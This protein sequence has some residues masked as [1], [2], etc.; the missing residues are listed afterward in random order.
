MEKGRGGM[1]MGFST[2][3]RVKRNN[4]KRGLNSQVLEVR[5][6]HLSI[7]TS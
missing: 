4:K 1:L 2:E 7:K 6:L 5:G 3:N